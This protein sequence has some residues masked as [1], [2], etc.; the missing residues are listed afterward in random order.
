MPFISFINYT[1]LFCFQGV[2]LPGDV[3]DVDSLQNLFS[4]K[5]FIR[6]IHVYNDLFFLF[7]FILFYLLYLF[8]L[9]FILL[10]LFL[11][12]YVFLYFY[13]LLPPQILFFCDFVIYY[14]RYLIVCYYFYVI[15]N[16]YIIVSKIQ[17]SNLHLLST[18]FFSIIFS[19]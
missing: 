6:F 2:L 18:F 11:I 8:L 14:I 12:S 3:V 17:K 4:A 7:Y 19:S 9:T 16:T 1:S 10:I 13:F 15:S 5:I